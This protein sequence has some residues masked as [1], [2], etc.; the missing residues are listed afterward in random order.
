MNKRQK[1]TLIRIILSAIMILTLELLNLDG[2]LKF[3]LYFIPYLTIGYDILIKAVKGILR[4]QV[5]SENFLMAIASVGAIV[6]GDGLEGSAVMLFYQVGELF[7]SVA[8]GKSRKSIASLM[9]IRPDYAFTENADGRLNKVDPDEVSVGTIIVVK[10]G[11]KIPIDGIVVEGTTVIDTS[12]LTGESVPKSIFVG[13]EVISGC[14]NISGL[15]KIRTTK[16][17]GESTVS[18]ILELVENASSKKSR[19]ENFISRFAKYYTPA[20]CLSAVALAVFP[21]LIRLILG[22]GGEWNVWIYRALTFLVISCPCAL[23]ISVPLGF[24]AGLGGAS[25]AGILIKGSNY[26][27]ALSK[28]KCVAFDKTGTLTQGSFTVT[29]VDAV[30]GTKEELI[31]YASH[32]EGYSNHPIAK[33]IVVA[34]GSSLDLTRVN[35]VCE[36]SGKGVKAVVDGKTVLVGNKLIAQE[37]GVKIDG[38]S[39]V[40]TAVYVIIDGVYYGRIIIN[41]KIKDTAKDAIVA[42]KK[43]GVTKTVMLTGDISSVAQNVGKTVCVDEIHASLLPADKVRI[44]ERLISEKKN[45]SHKVAFVGDGV[46]DAPTLMRA[47]VGIAMGALGSDSA[48]EAADVVLMDDNPLK[49]SKAVGISKKC[50][51]IIYQNIV[52]ALGVKFVCLILGVLGLAEMW[53]AIFAD[54]GVMV[55]AVLNAIRVMRVKNIK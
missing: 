19:S 8:L 24:F 37:T 48:I 14:V 1:K 5:F 23:V 44:V 25:S 51:H 3:W 46:N 29:E 17:F 54:V 22:F 10:A 40:G 35:G 42:L 18:K 13:D 34:Y 32:A 9:D 4:G 50:M 52:F 31:R 7:Q 12:A 55:L 28:I 47:D 36:I 26:L 11:E 6:L 20:V 53:L 38:Y 15:I 49:I 2:G 21:P 30:K 41:D 27:E 33:S 39:G 16:E 45:N 43:A